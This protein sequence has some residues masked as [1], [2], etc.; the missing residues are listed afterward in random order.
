MTY[1]RGDVIVE[2]IEI[3]DI[4][5]EYDY[6]GIKVVVLEKPTLDEDGNWVWKS[7]KINYETGERTGEIINYLVNPKY[8]HYS[9]KLYTYEAY[10]GVQFV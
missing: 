10:A 4:H 1:T 9:V 8:P 6:F 3:G 5:Y 7:E 2:E